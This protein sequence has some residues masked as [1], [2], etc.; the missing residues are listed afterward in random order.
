M[1]SEEDAKWVHHPYTDALTVKIKIRTTNIY[2]VLVDNGIA[3][4]VWTYDVYKRLGFPDKEMT[5]SGGHLYGFT[6]ASVEVKGT[7]QLLISLGNDPCV[8]ISSW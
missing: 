4:N 3:V 6:G 5:P 8:A 7:V 1:L 2:R